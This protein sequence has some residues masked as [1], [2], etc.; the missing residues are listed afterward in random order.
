MLVSRE[1]RGYSYS[2]EPKVIYEDKNFLAVCK[3]A[4]LLVHKVRSMKHGTKE[5]TL[6]DWFLTRYPEIKKVGDNPEERPGIVHRLDRDTSGVILVARNQKFF[7]YFKFLFQSR[8]VV[9]TYLAVVYGVP[10]SETSNGAWRKSNK[11]EVL[12]PGA[13]KDR[14][15]VIN[16]PI[17][18]KSGTTKR[19]VHSEKDAKTAET[20][21]KVLKVFE[22]E[23]EKYSL[24]EVKPKTGRTHQI[25][26]HLA[27]IG[28]P[29]VGDPLYGRKK[30]PDWAKRLMLH[31]LALEF[32]LA[33]GKPACHRHAKALAGRRI[34][35]EAEPPTEFAV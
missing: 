27:S 2:V 26:V 20:E 13:P 9:K 5:P 6:V 24:L 10:G 1:R 34:K 11:S 30:Q 31:A 16:L 28:S 14:Y 33:D 25:R 8:Q 29:V 12:S 15:G 7:D 18:I 23:G 17:G 35:I 19:S 21:Y 32:N 4:G 22:R 3:P